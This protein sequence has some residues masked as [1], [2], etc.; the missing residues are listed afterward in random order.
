MLARPNVKD[1][2]VER[3]REH[4]AADG[5]RPYRAE[6]IAQWLYAR[7]VDAPSQMTDLPLA[8]R[9]RLAAEW[10]TRA[11]ELERTRRAADGTVKGVLRAQDGARIES[12]LIPEE[13]RTTLCVST[14]RW[15][16]RWRAAS[17]RPASWGSRAI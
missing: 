13:E 1:R 16:A 11:L 7:G 2:S 6:Q 17:A 10:D 5:W 8:D 4:L 12:V 15:A 9:A 3:L 14:P